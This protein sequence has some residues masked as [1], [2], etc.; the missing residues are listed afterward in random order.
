MCLSKFENDEELRL[1]SR[2]SHIFHLG[3]I[4]SWLVSRVTCLVYH[5]SLAK[6]VVDDNF[7]LLLVA[8]L[9]IDITSL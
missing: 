3:C 8:T 7:D 2:C 5:T 4:D 9:T 1:L 6:Q